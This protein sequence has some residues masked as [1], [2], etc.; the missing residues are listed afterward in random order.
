[1]KLIC[2]RFGALLVAAGAM[3]FNGVAMGQAGAVV[4]WG[5]NDDGQ[6]TIPV[7]AQSGVIAVA[8][9][10][11]HTVALKNGQVIAWGAGTVITTGGANQS[12]G[13]NALSL[14]M[15]CLEFLQ[16]HVVIFTQWL[17]N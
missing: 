10:A 12:T 3:A 16:L 6:C 7:A 13:D 17:L 2:N 15:Q 5:N 1:M 9:G 4:A 14:A 8:G 11:N